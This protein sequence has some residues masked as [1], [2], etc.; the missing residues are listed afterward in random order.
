MELIAIFCAIVLFSLLPGYT[1]AHCL[2]PTLPQRVT[3]AVA[4]ALTFFILLALASLLSPSSALWLGK[5]GFCGSFWRWKPVVVFPLVGL[6]TIIFAIGALFRCRKLTYQSSRD[7]PL[8]AAVLAGIT[9][10]IAPMVLTINFANPAQRWDPS[11]HYNGLVL[12]RRTQDSHPFYALSGL[13]PQSARVYYPSGWHIFTVLFTGSK[14]VVP[15]ANLMFLM[16]VCWWILGVSA[17]VALLG[18]SRRAQLIT[19]VLSGFTLSFPADSLARY[20]QWPNGTGIALLPGAV[21]LMLVLGR[22]VLA[23]ARK[24]SG[25]STAGSQPPEPDSSDLPLTLPAVLATFFTSL[26]VGIGSVWVHPAIFFNLLALLFPLLAALIATHL[27]RGIRKRKLSSLAG[28]LGAAL[29]LLLILEIG[30]LNPSSLATALFERKG[31]EYLAFLRPLLPTPFFFPSSAFIFFMALMAALLTMGIIALFYGQAPKWL[32]ASWALC[33]GLVMISY[34]PTSPLKIVTGPWYSDPRRLMAILQLP[35]NLLMGVG[36]DFMLML[37]VSFLSAVG[38]PGR[39]CKGAVATLVATCLTVGIAGSDSRVWA[40]ES[41]FNPEMTGSG[42][43]S[44]SGE[45]RLIKRAAH[46]LPADAVIVGDPSIGT[47][48]FES[49]ANRRVVFSSL[50]KTENDPDRARLFYHLNNIGRDRQVCLSLEK[51]KVTHFYTRPDSRYMGV[52]RSYSWPGFYQVPLD[53]Y[54]TQV[55]SGGRAKLYRFNGCGRERGENNRSTWS[56]SLESGGKAR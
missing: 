41:V 56:K 23:Y 46:F 48:Y 9:A 28:W 32:L 37:T 16:L 6:L 8:I 1:L 18:V 12:L 21:A 36:L 52:P 5:L 2:I 43:L 35:L 55:A 53:G 20:A 29:G 45:L 11:F 38:A 15:A 49:I 7:Y 19:I 34:L 54:F 33:A 30:F 10:G 31:D 42:G 27:Y 47:I 40:I 51:L 22:Q 44:N 26:F 39:I 50:G 4:P 13:Y 14:S 3:L 25:S 17:L 24:L